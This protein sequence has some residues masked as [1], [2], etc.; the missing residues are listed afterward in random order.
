MRPSEKAV[1]ITAVSWEQRSTAIFKLCRRSVAISRV[2]SS[3]QSTALSAP[4]VP[5]V[6]ITNGTPV[7]ARASIK[8]RHSIFVDARE[9][10][11]T[12]RPR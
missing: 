7:F 9:Y 10:F 11:D 5:D 2:I 6:P 4:Q 3:I 1:L 12:P 8:P